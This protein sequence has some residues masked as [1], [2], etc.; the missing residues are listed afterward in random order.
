MFEE[1]LKILEE[2]AGLIRKEDVT[3]DE[4]LKAYE[5]AKQAGAKPGETSLP[6]I[7]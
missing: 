4:A 6:T 2:K 5:E 1:K 3:L 7:R